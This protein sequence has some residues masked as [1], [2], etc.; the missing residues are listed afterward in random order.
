MVALD[1][2][3]KDQTAPQANQSSLSGNTYLNGDRL[4]AFQVLIK[5]FFYFSLKELIYQ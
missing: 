4:L 2:Y 1:F 3:L 5:D